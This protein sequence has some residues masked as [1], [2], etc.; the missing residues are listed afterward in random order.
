[1]DTRRLTR[2]LALLLP[3]L[4]MCAC[5]LPK[6]DEL[7]SPPNPP[8]EYNGLYTLLSNT[9]SSGAV[10]ASPLR[11]ENR[12]SIQFVDLDNDGDNEAL[13][14]FK[15]PE[16]PVLRVYVYGQNEDDV[17]TQVTGIAVTG[18]SIDS[19]TY[20]DLNND[21]LMDIVVGCRL[22]SIKAIS[23]YAFDENV[24]AEIY[25]AE[26]TSY[27]IADMTGDGSKSLLLLNMDP[28]QSTGWVRMLRYENSYLSEMTTAPLSAGIS[29]L[30]RVSQGYLRDGYPALFVTST[31]AD[32]AATLLTDLL[33]FKDNQLVNITLD[34]VTGASSG[35][36]CNQTVYA[37]NIDNDPNGV[38]DVPQTVELPPFD[39]SVEGGDPLYLALWYSYD[40]TGMQ[41]LTQKTYYTRQAGWYWVIPEHWNDNITVQ[42]R[43]SRPSERVTTIAYHN[44]A[45]APPTV[46][47]TFYTITL[48]LDETVK[49]GNRVLLYENQ[50][51]VVLVEISP[52]AD[53]T[54]QTLKSNFYL[55]PSE[56]MSGVLT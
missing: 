48:S 29:A 23:V 47:L 28:S 32:S 15:F 14:F 7:L 6:G 19:I 45:E 16:A 40:S 35:T 53:I 33:V 25:T 11:G 22:G 54:E 41:T 8:L 2:C 13:V 1:M 12:Q 9:L 49:P 52:E 50:N 34:E 46:L 31:L 26:C 18:D 21:S 17:Y 10:Y 38:V 37:A 55:K 56:W 4:L 39:P 44:G 20:A 30:T 24:L 51:T 3:F 43:E 27:A 42:M 36:K 5:S